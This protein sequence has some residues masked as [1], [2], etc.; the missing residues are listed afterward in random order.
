MSD[1]LPQVILPENLTNDPIEVVML[2]D[3]A[4]DLGIPDTLVEVIDA[5]LSEMPFGDQVHGTAKEISP[6]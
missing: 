5:A 2:I 6:F 3:T 1:N 4:Q